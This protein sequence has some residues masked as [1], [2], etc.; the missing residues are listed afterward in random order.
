MSLIN[1]ATNGM[2][3]TT[4][5]TI[6]RSLVS[7]FQISILTRHLQKE[8]FGTIA[9]ATVFIGF[10]NLFLDL[11]ISVGI[12]HKQD[13]S[14]EQYSSLFWL[15]IITGFLLTILLIAFSPIVSKSYDDPT[16]TPIIMLLSLTVFF[17]ALGSQHRTIQQKELRFKYIAIV[18]IS[19]S[20]LT[21]LVAV[22][23]AIKGFGV[24]SLVYSTLFGIFFSNVIFLFIGLKKDR[25]I[26]FHFNLK[27][28][29]SFLKIGV[30][31]IGSRV[32]DYFSREIDIIFI[33]ASFGKDVLGVYT[34]CKKIVQMIYGIINPILTKIL[35]PL[36]AK[37]QNE[38]NKI[39][40]VYLSLIESLS[41]INFPVYFLVSIF[42]GAILNFLYGSE[43]VEGKFM[44]SILALYYGILS[45][46]N[47]VGSLQ[48]A[49]GRT[50]IGFYWTIFRIIITLIIVYIASFF[51]ID[52]LVVLFLIM[53]L[54][55]SFLLWRFQIYVMI[56]VK[57]NEYFSVIL[58]PLFLVIILSI[59]FYLILWSKISLLYTITGIL[60]FIIVYLLAVNKYIS[61]SYI[62]DFA[63][64]SLKKSIQF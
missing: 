18:E 35:T 53:A 54:V 1:V 28:T 22:I 6:V 17:A 52:T 60:F 12:M 45:I 4:A 38:R 32:L 24:Y 10:T 37:I 27:E 25:N 59:P 58:R 51:S 34:L 8:D 47:P 5:S 57:F 64:K 48:I 13:I 42:S 56:K 55:N 41:I 31:S 36:F 44:L 46:S 50:D 30:Y 39:K 61:N 15:N 33:S 11:G 43:Y 26:Y 7:L 63:K 62:V 20:I 19:G 3:W 29:Y 21:M 23:T 49:L 14:R 9:I 2:I 40:N 16:L